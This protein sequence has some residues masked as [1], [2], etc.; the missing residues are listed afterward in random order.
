MGLFKMVSKIFSFGD[1][2]VAGDELASAMIPNLK[3]Q[4]ELLNPK[5]VF[6]EDSGSVDAKLTKNMKKIIDDIQSLTCR[7][8]KSW[9]TVDL[10]NRQLSFS[11]LVASKMGIECKN[12][13]KGGASLVHILASI[14]RH[15]PEIKQEPNP[16]VLVGMTGTLRNS[17]FIKTENETDNIK[18]LYLS[19]LS[20]EYKILNMKFGDDSMARLHHKFAYI[21]GIS[22]L[23]KDIPH[24]IL[25][26]WGDITSDDYFY[27]S[28]APS[29][30][31]YTDNDVRFVQLNN[32][33]E[34][35]RQNIF[36]YSLSGHL[37][38]TYGNTN[39]SCLLGHPLPKYHESYANLIIKYIDSM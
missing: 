23:L 16:F 33:K 28:Y 15:L 17:H 30:M 36:P 31:E 19:D 39:T 6:Y 8:Y 3:T 24:L 26:T 10:I 7:H 34:L 37:Y 18:I 12:Y 29:D 22:H 27:F 5:N 1:S 21:Y 14:I 9:T 38:S 2:Y 25:D 32:T 13:A 4:L 11:N 20:D 35:L